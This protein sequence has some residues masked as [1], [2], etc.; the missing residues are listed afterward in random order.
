MSRNSLAPPTP[1]APGTMS[2]PRQQPFVLATPG[3]QIWTRN[4]WDWDRA[5]RNFRD[6]WVTIRRIRPCDRHLDRLCVRFVLAN[7]NPPAGYPPTEG[8]H[9]ADLTVDVWMRHPVRA[10]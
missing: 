9:H 6:G 7:P 4:P 8:P 5:A 10:R 2:A 1:I 3:S